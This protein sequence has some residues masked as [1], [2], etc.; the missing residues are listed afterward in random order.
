[1]ELFSITGWTGAQQLAVLLCLGALR[2]P[3]PGDEG[4]N[5]WTIRKNLLFAFWLSATIRLSGSA[6]GSLP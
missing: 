1:M 5:L 2:Q 3:Q 6:T 4:E